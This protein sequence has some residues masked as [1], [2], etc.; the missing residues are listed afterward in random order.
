[1]HTSCSDASVRD[2][3][4]KASFRNL[5]SEYSPKEYVKIFIEKLDYRPPFRIMSEVKQYSRAILPEGVIRLTILGSAHGLDSAVLKHGIQSEEIIQRWTDDATLKVPFPSS[6]SG[7]EITLVDIEPESLRYAKDMNLAEHTFMANL[8]RPYSAE[9]KKHL[10]E[11]TDIIIAGGI[12]SYIGIEGTEQVFNTCFTHGNVKAMFFSVLKYLDIQKWR[13]LCQQYN[14]V[15]HEIG[16]FRQRWYK[17]ADEKTRICAKLKAQGT[18]DSLDKEG[19]MSGLF[20]ATPE[21]LFPEL[22]V[23][24]TQ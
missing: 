7:Y 9:L 2:E 17:H 21:G 6:D 23:A 24:G 4:L 14:L 19:L 20:L 3:P 15:L 8:R 11:H 18:L 10:S 1:M 5:Y 12:T 13:E 16:E 22:T